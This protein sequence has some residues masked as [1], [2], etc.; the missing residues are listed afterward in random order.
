M[1]KRK[2]FLRQKYITLQQ[3]LPINRDMKRKLFLR[4]K[5]IT[6]QQTLPINRDI[7]YLLNVPAKTAS[8]EKPNVSEP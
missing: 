4:Q 5:Y 2:L 6:L 1:M 3:T 7:K 8:E